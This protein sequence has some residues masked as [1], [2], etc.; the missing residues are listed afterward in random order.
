MKIFY[1]ALFILALL[2]FKTGFSQKSFV[3]HTL[4]YKIYNS[5]YRKVNL[6]DSRKD[7]ATLGFVNRG[8]FVRKQKVV[9][10]RLLSKQLQLVMDSLTDATAANG[11]LLF[12]LR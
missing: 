11:E 1:P 9:A 10:G 2:F 7:S 5:L 3:I 12:D 4:P 6:L 8:F